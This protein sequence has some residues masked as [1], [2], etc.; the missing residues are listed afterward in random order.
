M[1]RF[2]FIFLDGMGMGEKSEHNPVYIAQQNQ[3]KKGIPWYLPFYKDNG[4][5]P[6]NTPVKSID[7]LLGVDGIPQ[8][9]TGQ[10]SLFTGVNIPALIGEHRA[11]YPTREMRKVIREKNILS[12]LGAKNLK[13]IFGN[14]YPFFSDFFT[15]NHVEILD[16]GHFHFSADFPRLY[17]RRISTTSCMI[18]ANGQVPFDETDIRAERAIYQEYANITLNR[19]L[20]EA[21]A[22]GKLE[23]HSQHGP[24]P[25]FSPE[26]AA[27][28]LYA[29]F[30]KNDF[31]LYEYFQTDI[32]GHR[33]GFGEKVELVENLNRLLVRLFSLMDADRDTFLLTSDH[34]NMEDASIRSH[35]LNPVPLVVW[36]RESNGLRDGIN[37]LTD[38]TPAIEDFFK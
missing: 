10:T 15:G 18:I 35:T 31:V 23:N 32:I 33:G 6:D 38:V 20:E 30:Q 34:G 4:T 13:A 3:E 5:L 28:I 25:E 12:R 21:K 2:L 37:A 16:D 27:E 1:K 29:L 17:K 11:S 7:A 26:K 19:Q 14:V 22:A 36:G 8:S 9:A 24:L